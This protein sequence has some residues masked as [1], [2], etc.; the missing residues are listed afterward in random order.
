VS[1]TP[2]DIQNKR[3]HDAFRG[4][5]HEEVDLF[6]DQVVSSF[7]AL[8]AELQNARARLRELEAQADDVRGT[9]GMLKR[10]LIAAQRAADEAVAE[11]KA[12][13]QTMVAEARAE[14]QKMASASEQELADRIAQANERARAIVDEAS[15]RYRDLEAMSEKLRRLDMEHRS[16]LREMLEGQL[17][18]LDELPQAPGP[19]TVTDGFDEPPAADGPLPGPSPPAGEGPEEPVDRAPRARPPTRLGSA[20][21]AGGA[22]EAGPEGAEGAGDVG[23][24]VRKL[25]WGKD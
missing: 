24:S 20:P 4:Y 3:F 15:E 18:A 8:H 7:N 5:N 9:E 6:L 12:E 19:I 11:A 10:T 21:A 25:F 2:E 1:L 22:E 14:A 13:A 17:R 23:P 16:R